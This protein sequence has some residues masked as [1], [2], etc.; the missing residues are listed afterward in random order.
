MP[1]INDG[2]IHRLRKAYTRHSILRLCRGKGQTLISYNVYTRCCGRRP[3]RCLSLRRPAFVPERCTLNLFS[4]LQVTT[5][6]SCVC[7]PLSECD[8]AA[9]FD[10]MCSKAALEKRPRKAKMLPMQ[11]LVLALLIALVVCVHGQSVAPGPFAVPPYQP[12]L[13]TDLWSSSDGN[14][15]IADCTV[16]TLPLQSYVGGVGGLQ[17]DNYL[18]VLANSTSTIFVQMIVG[19]Y[20]P[21]HNA[22]VSQFVTVTSGSWWVALLLTCQQCLLLLAMDPQKFCLMCCCFLAKAITLV[23]MN[24]LGQILRHLHLVNVVCVTKKCATATHAM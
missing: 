13:Y 1:Q 8:A 15:H 11:T 9:G 4:V 14:T 10:G 20:T 6:A 12:I 18:G 23:P 3:G 19:Q 2:S 22:P 5:Q 17:A 16:Q 7:M 24:K 21:P